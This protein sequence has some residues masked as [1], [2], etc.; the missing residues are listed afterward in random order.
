MPTRTKK[1][2]PQSVAVPRLLAAAQ[3]GR[4]VV[5]A[6]AGISVD[7]PTALPSWWDLSGSVVRAIAARAENVVPDASLLADVI[8]ARQRSDRFPPDWV[9]EKIVHSIG[10]IYFE[11]L[12]CIDSDRPNAN[13]LSLAEL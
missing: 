13:H 2:S 4:L 12:R 8:V 3:A 7:P 1:K 6:G 10:S 9:A 5:F 11:V